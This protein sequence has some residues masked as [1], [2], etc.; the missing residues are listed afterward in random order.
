M[1]SYADGVEVG[2]EGGLTLPLNFEGNG[3]VCLRGPQR[4]VP[5]PASP[6]EL[7]MCPP[8]H[9][10]GSTTPLCEDGVSA[11]EEVQSRLTKAPTFHGL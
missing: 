5:L 10:D 7:K 9:Q 8:R 2:G 3:G 6:T 11:S 1:T 4:S